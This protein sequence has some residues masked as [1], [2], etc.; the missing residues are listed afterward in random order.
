MGKLYHFIFRQQV[1]H[2]KRYNKVFNQLTVFESLNLS[3]L[4]P[5]L[6]FSRH[7]FW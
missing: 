6:I 1:S 4:Q 2:N 5:F 7:V 3:L